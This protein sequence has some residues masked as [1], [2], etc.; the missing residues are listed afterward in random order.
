MVVLHTSGSTGMPKPIVLRQGTFAIGD[1]FHDMPNYQG[2]QFFLKEFADRGKKIFL[3]L[4]MFHVAGSAFF[5][6]MTIYYG[7]Q[8]RLGIPDQPVS[9][10]L[11]AECLSYA[12]VD[13]AF[14]SPSILEELSLNDQGIEQLTKLSYVIFGGGKCFWRG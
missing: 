11:V 3:T 13:A 14:L 8:M 4:P 6:L 9:A 5:T 12:D 7:G 2:A 10:E 1:A